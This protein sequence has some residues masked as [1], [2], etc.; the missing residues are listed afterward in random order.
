MSNSFIAHKIWIELMNVD[1]KRGLCPLECNISS[2]VD[3][4]IQ[5]VEYMK[6]RIESNKDSNTAS[7]AI[8][9]TF[10]N[11]PGED[12]LRCRGRV[13]L[14]RRTF[15]WR[16]LP[17][18]LPI[19]RNP[20]NRRPADPLP[21]AVIQR[22]RSGMKRRRRWCCWKPPSNPFLELQRTY[23]NQRTHSKYQRFNLCWPMYAL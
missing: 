13:E 11:W 22:R 4:A 5:F 10:W 1:D 17:P 7:N 12:Y 2:I 6:K 9:W 21:Q 8:W 15:Q 3:E 16:W 19:L 14:V 20:R 23:F 18:P